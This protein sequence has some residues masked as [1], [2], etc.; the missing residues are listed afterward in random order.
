M[1]TNHRYRADIIARAPR[2]PRKFSVES[3]RVQVAVRDGNGGFELSWTTRWFV[4]DHHADEVMHNMYPNPAHA[5]RAAAQL[6]RI[7]AE[8]DAR[9]QTGE[10]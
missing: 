8:V 5:E 4:R 3:K 6:E 7:A 10:L 2:K 9:W 1:A